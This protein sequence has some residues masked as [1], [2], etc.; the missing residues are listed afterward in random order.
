MH[1]SH[2][3]RDNVLMANMVWEQTSLYLINTP[4]K[5]ANKDTLLPHK[6]LLL[7]SAL[8]LFHS[9][10]SSLFSLSASLYPSAVSLHLSISRDTGHINQVHSPPLLPSLSPCPPNLFLCSSFHSAPDW[11]HFAHFILILRHTPPLLSF[12]LHLT[13][14]IRYEIC[15]SSPPV[16]FLLPHTQSQK[17]PF[18]YNKYW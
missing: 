15:Y 9:A 1:Y 2:T 13:L 17:E 12:I 4:L 5:I 18:I 8:I 14:T 7:P 11:F 16:I 10:S 6:S 3:L